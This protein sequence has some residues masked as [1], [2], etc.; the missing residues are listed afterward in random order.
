MKIS[1]QIILI[2]SFQCLKEPILKKFL[3]ILKFKNEN[4]FFHKLINKL[5]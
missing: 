4:N 5:I 2:L 1:Q 3:K